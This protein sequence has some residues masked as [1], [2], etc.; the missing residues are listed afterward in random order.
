M[1]L[2]LAIA[3]AADGFKDI[4]DKGNQPYIL[5]CLRVMNSMPENDWEL[6][7]I[8][9]LHDVIEDEV[10]TL[11][12]LIDLKFSDRIIRGVMDLTHNEMDSYEDYIKRIS[13]NKDAVKVKLADL[14]D[15]SDINRLKGLTKKD[16]DRMEK[17]HKAYIYLS[18]I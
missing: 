1:N 10:C 3:I 13:L 7:A 4:T 12:Q 17:Y 11:K 18:K 5:H 15:N 9:V 14:R 2:G 16:F 8:A 6:R